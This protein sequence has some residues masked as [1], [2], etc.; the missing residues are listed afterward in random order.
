MQHQE[1]ENTSIHTAAVPTG[2]IG[3]VLG[4]KYELLSVLGS[5]GMSSVYITGFDG[6]LVGYSASEPWRRAQ[7]NFQEAGVAHPL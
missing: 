1:Q 5:G 6:P 3:T 2:M 7:T 4:S